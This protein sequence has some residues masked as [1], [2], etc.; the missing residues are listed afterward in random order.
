MNSHDG[1]KDA[2]TNLASPTLLY[3]ELRRELARAKRSGIGFCA[4]KIILTREPNQSSVPTVSEYGEYRDFQIS[5][6]SERE[7]LVFSQSLSRE[8]R[9]EDICARMGRG[10]F[11]VLLQDYSPSH[12]LFINRLVG[13]WTRRRTLD[14]RL[15]DVIKPRLEFSIAYSISG[16][17]SLDLLNRLDMEPTFTS[18]DLQ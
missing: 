8:T 16:E 13:Q 5:S 9:G 7:I 1:L 2:L 11:L 10:E 15:N 3:E 12:V 14:R 4:L 17:S 18:A 6:I